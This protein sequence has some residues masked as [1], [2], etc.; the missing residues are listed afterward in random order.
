MEL[1]WR[2]AENL[3]GGS[4]VLDLHCE[5]LANTMLSFMLLMY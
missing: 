3:D 2:S 5:T 4:T 1:L